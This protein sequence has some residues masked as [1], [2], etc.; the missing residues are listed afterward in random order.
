M[1]QR[2]M[3]HSGSAGSQWHHAQACISSWNGPPNYYWEGVI[4]SPLK[5]QQPGLR[6][7]E[8]RV[9]QQPW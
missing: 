4:F 2:P 8:H 7:L 9:R 3:E 6:D 5:G 1:S